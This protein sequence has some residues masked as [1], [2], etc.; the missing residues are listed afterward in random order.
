MAYLIGQSVQ[1]PTSDKLSEQLFY[2][3]RYVLK[4]NSWVCLFVF[5]IKI[6][7]VKHN[8]KTYLFS[9]QHDLRQSCWKWYL[10][11]KQTGGLRV[12]DSRDNL[13]ENVQFINKK[14]IFSYYR[15]DHP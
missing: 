3:W 10:L 9:I 5:N 14:I 4:E 2:L 11:D 7:V 13:T 1:R 12:Y 8:F 6:I 15:R